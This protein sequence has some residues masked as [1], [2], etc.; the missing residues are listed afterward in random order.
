MNPSDPREQLFAA[1]D[2][3]ASLLA[4]VRDDQL[5]APTPCGDFDVRLLVAHV[6][7]VLEKIVSFAIN[8]R[9]P[10][11]DETLREQEHAAVLEA[12]ACQ[13]VDGH[14]P[15]A[16]SQAASEWTAQGRAAW[17]DEVLDKDITVGWGPI[18]PGRVVASIY[19]MEVLSHAWDLAVATGQP[20]E[21]PAEVAEAGLAAA[22]Q[23]LP[24]SPRG[25]E[26]G[27][28]FGAVVESAPGAGP[29]ERMANWTGRSRPA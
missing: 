29:T 11:D 20:S 23:A 4:N 22:Q 25:V 3:Y 17:T 10:T 12:L 5:G 27:I 6:S 28:P 7:S 19:L 18:L 8:G 26:H 13:V 15:A 24:A 14:T 2:W 21:A 9:P 16:R 1:Q